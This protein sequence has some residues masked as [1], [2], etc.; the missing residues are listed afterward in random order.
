MVVLHALAPVGYI[1]GYSS[2]ERKDNPL[3]YGKKNRQDQMLSTR[4]SCSS[5]F[6]KVPFTAMP[7]QLL[8]TSLN[9]ATSRVSNWVQHAVTF[10]SYCECDNIGDTIGLQNAVVANFCHTTKSIMATQHCA[11]I[12]KNM[13]S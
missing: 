1:R 3:G 10:M 5:P 13:N 7:V 9:I 11:F 6:A 8:V 4:I 2:N 12:K